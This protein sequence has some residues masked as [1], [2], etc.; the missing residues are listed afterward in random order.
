MA[1]LLPPSHL[2]VGLHGVVDVQKVDLEVL[3]EAVGDV[4]EAGLHA[5][6][7]SRQ[8][9]PLPRSVHAAQSARK[10]YRR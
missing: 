8:G 7:A 3:P 10:K 2:E 1:L 9:R 6:D 5:A 4:Q